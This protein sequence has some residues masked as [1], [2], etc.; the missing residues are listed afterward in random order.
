MKPVFLLPILLLSPLGG[1]E[2]ITYEDHISPIFEQSCLNCHNPD[3]KKGDLDLSSY[4]A[5]MTGGSGG[6]V[7]VPGDGASSKL[8]TVTTGMTEPVMPPEGSKIDKKA[9]D[10]IRAWIDGGVLE[11]KD[12]SAKKADRPKF[13]LTIDTNAGK[14]EGP[15]PMPDSLSLD[16]A[17]VAPQA[18]LVKAM[19]ASPWAPLIALT[20]QKQILLYHSETFRFLGSL[21]YPKGQP[22]SLS[23]HPS[24]KYLLAS[25]GIAGKSGQAIVWDITTGKELV[26]AGREFDSVLAA[27]LTPDL[28]TVAMGGPSRLLKIWN[29]RENQQSHSIKKHT[30]WITAVAASPDGKFFASGDRNGSIHVW[31]LA[32]NEIHALRDH[33]AGVTGLA[34]RSD[35]KL[36]AS[37]GEDGQLFIWDMQKGSAAKKIN[38]HPGGV[39]ALFYHRDGHVVTAGRDRV[40]KV[41]KPD[42]NER[43]AFRNLPELVTAVALSQ[44][45]KHL[46]SADY[47]GEV[48]A[49]DISSNKEPIAT[50]ESN[51]PTLESRLAYLRKK[52]AEQSQQVTQAKEAFDS[53]NKERISLTERI[54]GTKEAL[55]KN[56][57]SLKRLGNEVQDKDHRM[58]QLAKRIS[59]LNPSLEKA[60]SEKKTWGEE[61]QNLQKK[62]DE[63]KAGDKDLTEI[64][65]QLQETANK[66]K[67]ASQ[68]EADTTKQQKALAEERSQLETALKSLRRQY[69]E[70][71]GLVKAGKDSLTPLEK[72]LPELAKKLEEPKKTLELAAGVEKKLREDLGYWESA[73]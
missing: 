72:R 59:E 73:K 60:R 67:A 35:S 5:T 39:T 24:G 71:G 10:L 18:G 9:A 11:T 2:K 61:Q 23:F 50:L 22:E 53:L 49:Y 58:K 48:F 20:G 55:K 46:F 4:P 45:G 14:P 64:T 21:P 31:D 63:L 51:P 56:E 52:L 34:F 28:S 42:F 7:V 68:K 69:Q 62:H 16:P 41:F 6:K 19:A 40:V 32:G 3:K 38:A 17:F 70:I 12:S 66:R 37:T 27:A 15:P 30:D 36:L 8:Y 44:D 1:Q 57:D 47:N 54:K 65:K 13:E 26:T 43:V 29:T 33:Q 25:G